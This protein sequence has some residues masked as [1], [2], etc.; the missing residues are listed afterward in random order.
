LGLA[1]DGDADRLIAVDEKGNLVDGD[2]IMCICG[3]YLKEKG[4]LKK[5]T[6]VTTVMSNIGFFKAMEELDIATEKTKVGDR[7]VM[8]KMREGGYNLGG[9]QSGHI[10]FLDYNTTGDGMLTAVQLLRVVKEKG[11][12]LSGL[13]QKMKK[14]P[15]LLVNVRV[16]EKEGWDKNEAIQAK[17]AE[18]ERALGNNGRVLVRPSGTEPLIRVMAEGPDEEMLKKYVNQIAEEVQKQLA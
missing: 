5:N 18:A 2:Q 1:F 8:E 9:E 6:V 7:Y 11:Q 12:T 17:I 13:A 14:Y 4:R 16:K 3:D 15:Q 10:I